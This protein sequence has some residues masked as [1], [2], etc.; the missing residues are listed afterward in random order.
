MHSGWN[1]DGITLK[2]FKKYKEVKHQTEFAVAPFLF[3]DDFFHLTGEKD[4]KG[5]LKFDMTLDKNIGRFIFSE[6][7]KSTTLNPKRIKF[8]EFID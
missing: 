7:D 1:D 3:G 4:E 8:I 5:F 2:P 6:Y